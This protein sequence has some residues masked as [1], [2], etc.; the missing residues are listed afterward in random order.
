ML[1]FQINTASHVP[2]YRQLMD[3]V[4][5]H[6]ASGTLRPGDRLLV[7]TTVENESAV[8]AALSREAAARGDDH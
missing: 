8:R 4:K 7:V 3:Q 2:A 5:Y 6:L 1:L